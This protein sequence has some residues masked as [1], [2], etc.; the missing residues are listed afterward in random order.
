MALGLSPRIIGC[1]RILIFAPNLTDFFMEEGLVSESMVL[2]RLIADGGFID[3]LYAVAAF[4]YGKRRI[5]D[6][7]GTGV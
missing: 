4:K 3:A 5:L 2:E 6:K 1:S 7:E